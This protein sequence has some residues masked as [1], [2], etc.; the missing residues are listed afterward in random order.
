MNHPACKAYALA[1]FRTSK[2]WSAFLATLAQI[3]TDRK[4]IDVSKNPVTP[5][6][7]IVDIIAKITKLDTKQR[8]FVSLLVNKKRLLT[9][10]IIRQYYEDLLN[11]AAKTAVIEVATAT[12]KS[13]REKQTIEKFAKEQFQDGNHYT[14]QYQIDAQLIA[15]FTL[16]HLDTFIDCSLQGQLNNL[17]HAIAGS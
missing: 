16:H 3:T 9:S 2:K 8:A 14:F 6:Q 10:P 11:I 15:G 13:I 5:K 4:F 7:T 1:A 17:Q 12:D